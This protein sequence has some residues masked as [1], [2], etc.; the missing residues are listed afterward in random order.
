MNCDEV[1]MV[2]NK[3]SCASEIR[4]IAYMLKI[5]AQNVGVNWW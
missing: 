1:G 2:F 4:D 3:I 5:L